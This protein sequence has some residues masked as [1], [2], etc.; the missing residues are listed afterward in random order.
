MPEEMSYYESYKEKD[1]L[2]EYTEVDI[3]NIPVINILDTGIVN[4]TRIQAVAKIMDMVNAKKVHHVMCMNPYKIMRI[5]SNNDLNLISKKADMHLACGAGISWAARM[6][7]TPLR[8]VI[9]PSP[10][11]WTSSASPS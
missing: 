9:S 8:E 5:K 6:L 11:S 7:K 2:L 4:I 1:L 10:S 3:S